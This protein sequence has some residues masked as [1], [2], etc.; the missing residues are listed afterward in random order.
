[1]FYIFYQETF[2]RIFCPTSLRKIGCCAWKV[3]CRSSDN[4]VVQ[5]NLENGAGPSPA[6]IP[7]EMGVI[8]DA[9]SNDINGSRT[10]PVERMISS[11]TQLTVASRHTSTS[12]YTSHNT[13]LATP[14]SL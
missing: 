2:C 3:C 7:H 10:N 4:E 14:T 13:A 5:S 1:M 12:S 11:E 6:E 8:V 9:A